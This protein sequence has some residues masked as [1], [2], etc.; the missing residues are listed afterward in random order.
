MVPTVLSVC[1]IE[2]G[3]E[4]FKVWSRMEPAGMK[5]VWGPPIG[6][7]FISSESWNLHLWR[8]ERGS[9]PRWMYLQVTWGSKQSQE[10]RLKERRGF[11][12]NDWF[13]V[14][15]WQTYVKMNRSSL[16]VVYEQ[17]QGHQVLLDPRWRYVMLTWGTSTICTDRCDGTKNQC[18]AGKM[19]EGYCH[20]QGLL[21]LLL[22]GIGL[23]DRHETWTVTKSLVEL[24]GVKNSR[25][26]V[27][28]A[29]STSHEES[30]VYCIKIELQ[31]AD[32]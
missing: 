1:D 5:D 11:S 23:E 27:Q 10:R 19:C 6:P 28:Q 3:T 15:W 4:L 9:I 12:T 25:W 26:Q 24:L 21:Q 8:G 17:T 29:M 32:Q 16:I 20:D 31:D 7:G 18:K 30:M 13:G 22:I 2:D 14:M